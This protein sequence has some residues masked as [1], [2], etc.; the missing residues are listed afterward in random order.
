MSRETK[1]KA[2]ATSLEQIG[3]P[4]QGLA[5]SFVF[6]SWGEGMSSRVADQRSSLCGWG[7]SLPVQYYPSSL[8]GTLG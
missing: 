6:M 5:S 3:F 2:P 4:V 7:W 8:L 1:D